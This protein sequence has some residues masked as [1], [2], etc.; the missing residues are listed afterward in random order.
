MND[1]ILGCFHT[2]H[3]NHTTNRLCFINLLISI[4]NNKLRLIL[5]WMQNLKDLFDNHL[6]L[7]HK[8]GDESSTIFICNLFSCFRFSL[9]SSWTLTLTIKN[10][11]RIIT[12]AAFRFIF[13]WLQL[14][15]NKKQYVLL[16]FFCGRMFLFG[17][18][19]LS[20]TQM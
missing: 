7:I 11:W 8:G 17:M 13:R 19:S 5:I 3:L 18:M 6:V 20:I 2:T 10:T 4:I 15:A 12:A 14:S 16:L 9:H 1:V